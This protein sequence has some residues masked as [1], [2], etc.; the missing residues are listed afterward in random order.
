MKNNEIRSDEMKV[1]LAVPTPGIELPRLKDLSGG[2]KLLPPGRDKCQI[3]AGDHDPTWPHN[4]DSLYYQYYFFAE[5]G[6]WPTW[7]DA[8][9][10]CSDHT[11]KFWIEGLRNLKVNEALLTE[12]PE[13]RSTDPVG[14]LRRKLSK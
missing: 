2:F 5:N 6:R 13:T 9:S 11:K 1:K 3:C 14:E 7:I 8:M 4:R 12:S 10:H